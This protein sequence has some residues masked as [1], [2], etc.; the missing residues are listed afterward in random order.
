MPRRNQR[1]QHFSRKF[2]KS[3]AEREAHRQEVEKAG[4]WYAYL[5]ETRKHVQS[6][7][8]RKPR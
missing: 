6:D 3:E 8:N 4:G 2:L 5:K 1:P 7:D